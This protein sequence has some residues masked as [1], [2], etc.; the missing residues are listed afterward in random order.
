MAHG[1]GNEAAQAPPSV[2]VVLVAHNEEATLASTIE[3]FLALPDVAILVAED[4]SS[5]RTREVAGGFAATGCVRVTPP[6][7]RKGYSRAVADAVAH[8]RARVV[9][10]QGRGTTFTDAAVNPGAS[11]RYLVSTFDGNGNLSPAAAASAIARE[12]PLVLP[13]DDAFLTGPP[14]LVWRP[15][16]SAE[17]YNVQ[18]WAEQGAKLVKVF[19]IWPSTNRLQLSSTWEFEGQHHALTKGTYRW[20]VW[21]GIG[22]LKAARYGTLLGTHAFTIVR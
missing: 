22:P 18:I 11:Y 14:L 6:A 8:T 5:D 19:S 20:Y 1:G 17:Y 16:S 13:Q 9:V 12:Q 7:P 15:V 21:P 10:F 2:E 3:G 4:G